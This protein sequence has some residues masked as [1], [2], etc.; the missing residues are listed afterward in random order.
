[1]RPVEGALSAGVVQGLALGGVLAVAAGWSRS[2]RGGMLPHL[3]V[4]AVGGVA[5]ALGARLSALPPV[6]AFVVVGAAGAVLGRLA[7]LLDERARDVPQRPS[8]IGDVAVLGAAVACVGLLVPLQAAPL[9]MPPL[10][11]GALPMGASPVGG[12]GGVAG[13]LGAF[14]LGAGAAFLLVSSR[15]QRL[16]PGGLNPG[17]RWAAS[18][19]ALAASTVLAGG[20]LVTADE[21]ARAVVL[22]GA[23]P[24]GLAVRAAAAALAGRG[25]T[26]EAA[27]AGLGL[28]VAEALVRLI[29]PTGATILL[30]AIGIAVL[31]V[32]VVSQTAA[33]AAGGER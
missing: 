21:A 33:P 12:T 26:T 27:A 8:A 11:A 10:A 22:A 3:G 30:P 14:V 2:A 25:S 24:V 13:G 5:V 17:R 4:G 31:S 29:D 9:G 1:M 15:G 20:V 28:G 7:L 6:L 32:L 23:D 18:G 19:A 16:L